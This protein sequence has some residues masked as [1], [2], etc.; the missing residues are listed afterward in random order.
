MQ[1]RVTFNDLFPDF[2]IS[3]DAKGTIQDV[4]KYAHLYGGTLTVYDMSKTQ[5]ADEFQ[6]KPYRLS[7]RLVK[8]PFELFIYGIELTEEDYHTQILAWNGNRVVFVQP[9]S[10]ITLIDNSYL[11]VH[12]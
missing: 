7:Y 9:N 2:G 6:E 5:F 4:L 12:V 10:P 11:L 8:D 1:S 3:V